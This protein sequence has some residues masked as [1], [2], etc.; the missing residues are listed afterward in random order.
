MVL[1]AGVPV[2]PCAMVNTDRLQPPGHLVPKVIRPEVRFGKPLDF[3]RYKG[4]ESDRLVL[5]AITDEIMYELMRLSGQQY[6]DIY[7]T[8]AKEELKRGKQAD[9]QDGDAPQ[10]ARSA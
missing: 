2:I 10:V 4:M 7:A 3:S 5:R 8:K 9:H 6:V 1:E